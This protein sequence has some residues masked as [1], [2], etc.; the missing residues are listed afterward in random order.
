MQSPKIINNYCQFQPLKEVWI[1]GCYPPDFF[2]HLDKKTKEIF[3]HI[4]EITQKDFDN[5]TNLFHQLGVCVR[6]PEFSSIDDFLDE[7]ERLLKPPITPCDFA[8]VID[9]TLHIIPQYPSGIDPYQKTINEY[10]DNHQHVVILD[11]SKP[12]PL[13]YLQFASFVSMGKDLYIDY[14]PKNETEIYINE[15]AKLLAQ[16]HRVHVSQTGNHS[17]AVFCPLKPGY[18]IGSHFRKHYS[19]TFPGWKSFNLK[20][21][22]SQKFKTEQKWHI[23]GIDYLHFNK[24]ILKIANDWIGYIPE[25]VF[26]INMVVVDE[27]NIICCAEN[28]EMFRYFESIGI[29]PHVARFESKMFWDAGIHCFTRDIHRTGSMIDYWPNRGPDG[30]YRI[31]E[32]ND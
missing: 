9:D 29:T 5:L 14:D 8:L 15:I 10:I 27:K 6:R 21:P 22:F 1:G 18:L 12:D 30:I 3:H 24:E 7:Q 20:T 11:R 17:D 4:S 31:T 19:E 32:W 2:D 26:E 23:P 28:E 13:C 25:T 16:K